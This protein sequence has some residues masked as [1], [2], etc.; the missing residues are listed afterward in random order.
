MYLWLLSH[1]QDKITI[2]KYSK[3]IQRLDKMVVNEIIYGIWNLLERV[4]NIILDILGFLTKTISINPYNFENQPSYYIRYLTYWIFLV[5]IG[6]VL[7]ALLF[8]IINW[9]LSEF[10]HKKSFIIA[11]VSFSLTIEIVGLVLGFVEF[12]FSL[13][14]D[15]AGFI[16]ISY[17]VIFI[18]NLIPRR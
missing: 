1:K 9:A 16:I 12:A 10:V 6:L 4:L 3:Y 11:V 14:G 2:F 13:L 18:I 8:I 15:I 7:I 5:I 17:L